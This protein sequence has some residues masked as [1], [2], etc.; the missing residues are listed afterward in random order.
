MR[1]PEL[2]PTFADGLTHVQVNAARNFLTVTLGERYN[3][4]QLAE[5]A[6][7]LLCSHRV[8]WGKT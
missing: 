6:F 3:L 5:K 8:V 7:T 1:E 4:F 2:N